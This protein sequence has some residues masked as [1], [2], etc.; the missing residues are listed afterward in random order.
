MASLPKPSSPLPGSH[1]SVVFIRFDVFTAGCIRTVLAAVPTSY[2][3]PDQAPGNVV[4]PKE[5]TGLKKDSVLNV[6]HHT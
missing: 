4:L 3:M 6:S 5:Q 2:L 1:R